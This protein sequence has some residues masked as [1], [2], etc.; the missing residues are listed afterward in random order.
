MDYRIDAITPRELLPGFHGRM[1]HGEKMSLVFW[2]VEAGAEV[3][4]HHHPHEQIMHVL[5]GE[6]EFTVNGVTR[7][8]QPGELAVIPSNAPHGGK[9]LTACRLMDVFSPAREEYR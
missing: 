9:A 1:V 5:E 3:P 6:F 7:V 4:E 8:Y 2:D